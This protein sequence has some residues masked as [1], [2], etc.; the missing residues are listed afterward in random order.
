MTEDIALSNLFFCHSPVRLYCQHLF[1]C[2][3]VMEGQAEL[4]QMQS[5]CVYKC[6][7]LSLGNET[8][9]KSFDTR[10]YL[11]SVQYNRAIGLKGLVKGPQL[12][13]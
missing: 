5:M 4:G 2:V 3:Q 12:G 7:V 11:C 1:L 8:P 9:I 6:E 10:K 13:S